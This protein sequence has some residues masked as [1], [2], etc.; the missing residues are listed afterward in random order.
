MNKNRLTIK[1]SAMAFVSSFII[2]QISVLLV[3]AVM[4]FILSIVNPT[5]I[6][7]FSKSCVANLITTSTLYLAMFLLFKFFAKNKDNNIISKPS[8]KKSILYILIAIISFFA[9]YPIVNSFDCLIENLG[10]KLTKPSFNLS[11]SNYFICLI[12]MV[13][14]PAICEELLFRGLIF[15][16]LKQH[17]KNFAIILTSLM[18]AIYHMSLQQTIYPILFGLVLT[19]TMFKEN[20]IIYCILMHLTNN[21]LALTFMFFKI[22]PFVNKLW[23]HILAVVL[24]V[25]FVIFVIYFIKKQKNV[26]NIE[27]ISKNNKILLIIVLVIMFILW[28]ISNIYR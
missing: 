12:P 22:D 11:V 5:I 3:S 18:F 14:L 21:F 17:G 9:L 2:C 27:K 7:S 19:L 6:E 15:K 10:F 26:E 16:G 8:A 25:V 24:F 4:L 1:D 13:I 20:N 28:I 23:Y